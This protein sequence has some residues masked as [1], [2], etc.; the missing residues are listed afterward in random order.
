MS[1]NL[2][3][4]YFQVVATKDRITTE[5]TVNKGQC[6]I[7]L[8]GKTNLTDDELKI[9]N[10]S[11]DRANLY[12]NYYT[13]L[14]GLPMKLKDAGTIIHDK[15]E[16]KTFKGK[17]YLLLKVTYDKA[18]GSDA[19]YFYFNTKTY[20]LEV[21]QFFHDEDKNDGEYILLSDI[22]TINGINVP[23]VRAWYT[24]KN[25]TYLGTD[26]LEK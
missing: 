8:N 15:V 2:P 25:N 21:Y 1:I 26:T 20:A 18:V 22:E 23:K 19:W 10:L 9:H 13:Y 12:K 16:S 3:K 7:A 17:T 6:S 11:C 14:Y 24:N 4:Q 5:Y